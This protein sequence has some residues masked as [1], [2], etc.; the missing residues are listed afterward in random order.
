MS[1]GEPPP[2]GAE[3]ARATALLARYRAR[4][5]ELLAAAESAA[6]SEPGELRAAVDHL[7]EALNADLL[8]LYRDA[9]RGTLA[10]REAAILLPALEKLRNVLR[11]RDV[12]LRTIRDTLH[13]AV[14]AMPPTSQSGRSAHPPG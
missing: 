7:V 5:A 10:A 6:P 8:G 9:E 12:R 14:S 3:G 11:H 4:L 1:P 2:S 13:K